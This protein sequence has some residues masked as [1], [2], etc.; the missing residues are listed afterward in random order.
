MGRKKK[1]DMSPKKVR[2]SYTLDPTLVS[3]METVAEMN[4]RSVSSIFEEAVQKFLILVGTPRKRRLL[5]R[6][7]GSTASHQVQ[8]S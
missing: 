7:N 8:T 2:V 3:Q 5:R 4:S 6:P 1:G